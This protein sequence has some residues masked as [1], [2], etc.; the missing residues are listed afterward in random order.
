MIT[1]N[2]YVNP[3][4]DYCL[5]LGQNVFIF[6][7]S[8][9]DS[10]T[11]IKYLLMADPSL[12]GFSNDQITYM[13][14][15]A[16]NLMDQT[17]HG[18]SF[19]SCH[20][21]ILNPMLKQ[22]FQIRFLQNLKRIPKFDLEDFKESRLREFG[23]KDPRSDID[24]EYHSGT[25]AENWVSVMEFMDHYKV[26]ALNGHT[27]KWLEFRTEPSAT[28]STSH[29]GYGKPIQNPFAIYWDD[30]AKLYMN[31]QDFLTQIFRFIFKHL[32][33]GFKIANGN[34]RQ[35]GIVWWKLKI[36]AFSA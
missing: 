34:F 21:P 7:D 29:T 10:I 16:T 2:Q 20:A 26:M 28:P 15:I 23:E 5:K 22:D 33:W 11:E 24:L 8:G 18:R 32:H 19:L 4:Q 31:D 1:Y 14:T 12:S 35:A 9:S 36:I 17:E 27:H 3:Y 6:L 25:I 30:Y 13:N